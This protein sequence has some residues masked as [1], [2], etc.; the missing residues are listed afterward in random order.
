MDNLFSQGRPIE[1]QEDLYV[2]ER[3]ESGLQSLLRNLVRLPARFGEGMLG[4]YGDIRETLEETVLK[5]ILRGT[6][7]QS[8]ELIEESLKATRNFSPRGMF[9]STEEIKEKVT[10]KALG[11]YSEPKG[12]SEEFFDEAFETTGSLFGPGA[13]KNIGKAA[14]LGFPATAVKDFAGSL[15]ASKGQQEAAKVGTVVL[16]TLF[17]PK[18]AAKYINS[19]YDDVRRLMSKDIKI[20]SQSLRNSLNSYRNE[21]AEGTRKDPSK[22]PILDAVLNVTQFIIGQCMHFY[23]F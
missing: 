7:R 16:G 11:K 1:T 22:K 18:K 21:L 17:N 10:S 5:P 15:G 20:P 3:P 8:P 12:R 4:S 6:T 9:P 23:K 2:S 13:M 14:L 19:L